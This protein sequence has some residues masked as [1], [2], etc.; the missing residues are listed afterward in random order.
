MTTF[1]QKLFAVLAI[2][3][4]IVGA[5]AMTATLLRQR[6]RGVGRAFHAVGPIARW[7]AAAIA[8]TATAG[9]LYFS[10][11]AGYTPCTL[12]WYQRIAMYPLV[13]VLT[14]G[15][16]RPQHDIRPYVYPLAGI[17]ASVSL[18]HRYIELHPNDGGVCSASVPCSAIWFETF[19]VFTLAVMA[20]SGF[21][22]IGALVACD[23]TWRRAVAR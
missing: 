15:A 5:A 8:W 20:M 18:Y 9:S 6:S 12:C 21:F 19:G 16:I 2:V 14:A 23:A 13:V 3:A 1:L 10:E 7:G 11:V 22:A 17:G 4:L